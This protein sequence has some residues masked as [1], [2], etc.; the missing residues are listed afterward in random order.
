MQNSPEGKYIV[1]KL[2]KDL[3]AHLLYHNL[4][5]TL[6]VYQC[7][8]SIAAAEN[9][10]GK[11]LDLILVAALYHDS[12]YLRGRKGHEEHSCDIV[13]ETLPAYGYTPQEIAEICKLIMATQIPQRPE[14]LG[15]QI[16]CDA[17][18]DYLGRNDFEEKAHNLYLEMHAEGLISNEAD[19]NKLQLDFL[20]Q[21]HY[22]TRT[23]VDS[24][25]AAK[26]NNINALKAEK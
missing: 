14:S 23:A 10:T 9:V 4:D 26:E 16:L 12:G 2:Q 21:H 20:Q 25:N 7:T 1:D 8:Q 24:R 22:F 15:G 13:Q 11:A 6:D 18:L 3:P 17:D 5:H 19:W